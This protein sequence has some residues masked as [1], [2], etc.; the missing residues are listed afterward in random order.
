MR[1]KKPHEETLEELIR[2]SREI[3]SLL[4]DN[5]QNIKD[6]HKTLKKIE[7]SVCP[8]KENSML[9]LIR[10]MLNKSRRF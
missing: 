1:E 3:S 8:R 2:V 10:K 4:E 6:C 7:Q 9:S 5:A